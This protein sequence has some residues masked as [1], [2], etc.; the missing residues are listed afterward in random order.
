MKKLKLFL[1]GAA[2]FGASLLTVACGG[3]RHRLVGKFL[4]EV[5]YVPRGDSDPA[6]LFRGVDLDLGTESKLRIGCGDL[7]DI[8]LE[9]EQEVVKDGQCRLCGNRL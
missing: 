3:N 6:F 4:Q 1:F 2:I 5:D 8:A 9:I 7:Q